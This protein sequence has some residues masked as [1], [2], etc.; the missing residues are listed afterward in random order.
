[1]HVIFDDGDDDDVDG[2]SD[3]LKEKSRDQG[4][5]RGKEAFLVSLC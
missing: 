5:A 2:M 4:P 1:M 3:G